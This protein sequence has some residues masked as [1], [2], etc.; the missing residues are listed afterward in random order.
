MNKNFIKI[1][2]IL[3]IFFILFYEKNIWGYYYFNDFSNPS[4]VSNNFDLDFRYGRVGVCTNNG[5]TSTVT[6]ANGKCVFNGRVN[7]DDSDY[8]GLWVGRMVKFTNRKFTASEYNPFGVLIVRDATRLDPQLEGDSWGASESWRHL[9]A[10]S[11]WIFVETGLN[12][13]SPEFSSYNDFI[14]MY[15]MMRDVFNL[16]NP[17]DD[18]S[19]PFSTWGMYISSESRLDL[20]SA[21]RADGKRIVNIVNNTNYKVEWCYENNYGAGTGDTALDGTPNARCTNKNR[22]GLLIT[23]NGSKVK[24]YINPNYDNNINNP[25]PDEFL[26]VG[27]ANVTWNSNISFMFGHESKRRDTEMEYFTVDEVLIRSVASNSIAEIYPYE[28]VTNKKINFTLYITN[29]FTINDSGIGE[30]IIE[31]P[32]GYSLWDLSTISVYSYYG[33]GSVSS[34]ISTLKQLTLITTGTL[35]GN[36]EVLATTNGDNL[37]LQFFIGEPTTPGSNVINYD[38]PDKRI[39]VHFTLTSPVTPAP[40]GDEF[41]TYINCKKYN[42][43][44]YSKFATTGKKRVYSGDAV[45]FNKSTSLKVKVY[46][47][48]IAY[49]SLTPN[50]IYEGT[51]NT[52]YYYLS[53]TSTNPGTYITKLE[54]DIPQGFGIISAN[55]SSLRINNDD[56]YAYVTNN[57]VVIDYLGDNN[58]FPA[59]S[60]LDRVTIKAT[61]TPNISNE[62]NILWA[63]RIYST[64]LGAG[65]TYTK[66][67]EIYKSQNLLV[68]LEPPDVVAYIN[69]DLIYNNAK[70]NTFQYIVQNN[71]NPGNNVDKV[72]IILPQVFTNADSF[73][74]SIASVSSFTTIW[75]STNYIIVDYSKSGTNLP[76]GENDTISFRL[77]DTIPSLSAPTQ[78]E[79]PSYADNNN[80]DGFVL[81]SESSFGWSIDVI[82]PDPVGNGSI[83]KITNNATSSN[84]KSFYTSDVSNVFQYKIQNGDLGDSEND[85]IIAKIIIPTAFTQIYNV[86]STKIINDSQDIK[87]TNNTIV[88]YYTNT[89]NGHL[90]PGQIDKINF[91]VKDNITLPNSYTFDLKVANGKN[92]FQFYSTGNLGVENKILDAVYPPVMAKAFVKVDG[93]IGN[94]IDSSTVTNDLTYYIT[95]YGDI[96]N[97][98]KEIAIYFPTN[99]S[100]NQCIDIDS[101]IVTNS[102]NER[103]VSTGNY[104]FIDYQNEGKRLTGKSYDVIHFKMI[105]NISGNTSFKLSITGK[106]DLETSLLPSITGETQWVFIRIPPAYGKAS[107]SPESIFVV[108]AGEKVTNILHY[109]V[110]NYGWGSNKF[111]RARIKVPSV[112]A[113][114]VQNV[115]STHLTNESTS[116]IISSSYITINYTNENNPLPAQS[117]E[118][119]TFELVSDVTNPGVYGWPLEVDNGDGNGFVST[120]LM[121]GGTT[122]LSIIR[123]AKAA[124]SKVYNLYPSDVD[125]Y[126]TVTVSTL[127][128][129]ILHSGGTTDIRRAKI[130]IP[131]PFVTNNISVNPNFSGTA[132]ATYSIS[133]INTSNFIMINYPGGDFTSGE[134]NIIKI[135]VQDSWSTGET[136]CKWDSYVDFNDGNGFRKNIVAS[137]STTTVSF[138]FPPIQ[139]GGFSTPNNIMIDET[140]MT[141]SIYITNYDPVGN[142]IE[143]VKIILP[144]Q[145]TNIKDYTSTIIGT[146]IIYDKSKNIL[147]L[148]YYNF[149]T[150][151]SQYKKDTI[152][153]KGIDSVTSPVTNE[154]ILYAANSTNTN[155][156]V[157]VS[158][159]SGKNFNLNFYYPGYSS[160]VYVSPQQVDTTIT[161]NNLKYYVINNGSGTNYVTKVK[162]YINTNIYSTNSIF[163]SSL[164]KSEININENYILI[165]YIAS[166]TN[167]MPG[168]NDIINIKILDK[169]KYGDNT[170]T[171][172]SEI[173][174]NTS[175]SNYKTPAVLNGE[176]IN[177][178]YKMPSPRAKILQFNPIELPQ[179][180]KN[181][182]V[183]FSITNVGDGS[184]DIFKVKLCLPIYFTNKFNISKISSL[185]A[186]SKE[187]EKGNISLYYTNFTT[188]KKDNIQLILSNN[189]S[190]ASNL[191][192][193][194]T[195]SN[196]SHITNLTKNIKV[197][198]PPSVYITPNI[199][200]AVSL[201]NSFDFYILNNGTSSSNVKFAR[202]YFP[203]LITNISS[204]T[205]SLISTISINYTSNYIV[206]NYTNE[207]KS[208]TPGSFDKIS[209]IAYDSLARGYSNVLWNCKVDLSC[210]SLIDTYIEYNRSLAVSYIMPTLDAKAYIAPQNI[211]TTDISNQLVLSIVNEGEYNNDIQDIRVQIPFFFTN[212]KRITN[213]IPDTIYNYHS[214]SN[215]LHIQYNGDF[216]GGMSD[217]IKFEGFNNN[218][219]I[220]ELQFQVSGYNGNTNGYISLY[221]PADKTLI[222]TTKYPPNSIE[223][224]LENPTLY[225]IKTN[226]IIKYNIRNLSTGDSIK[227]IKISFNTNLLHLNRITSLWLGD[228]INSNYRIYSS[229]VEITYTNNLLTAQQKD[230]ISFYVSY[231]ISK[232][233]NLNMSSLITI[234]TETNTGVVPGNESVILNISKA[235]WGILKGNVYPLYKLIN[236]KVL[237]SEKD[238]VVN[239]YDNN[240]LVTFYKSDTGYYTLSKIPPG[241]YRLYFES[242]DLKAYTYKFSIESNIILTI[243]DIT[244]HNKPLS[245]D[246]PDKQSA[247]SY[248][249]YKSYLELKPGSFNKD[250]SVD[251]FIE[252]MT[253][254][255]Q[256]EDFEINPYIQN[257]SHNG[258]YVYRFNL[259]DINEQE[260]DGVALLNDGI[261]KLYYIS[262]MINST[263]WKE[264]DLGIYYFKEST[265]KWIPVG[266]V[267]DTVNKC[268]TTHINYVSRFFG[269]FAKSD[270]NSKGNIKNVVVSTRIFTPGRGNDDFSMVKISFSLADSVDNYTVS[271][272]DLR[273]D[274]IK[275]IERSG[276]YK[277]GSI[278]WDGKDEDGVIVKSG[279]YIYIIEADNETYKGSIL[280]VK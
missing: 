150:N 171:W 240:E 276:K 161:T 112:F 229:Y 48:P 41:K 64:V 3:I 69:P 241:E 141:Y 6:I 260:L 113:N 147:W 132:T 100:I 280:L 212:I 209:F 170:A 11:F 43:S 185:L 169:I 80:G 152:I 119:L 278:Y 30:I 2:Y 195:I 82:S 197:V 176:S 134:E 181:F 187:Y 196:F 219:I 216:K 142:S 8:V 57:K 129:K 210:N 199:V 227:D 72:K 25:Y 252:P 67:N 162:I 224:Y 116:I 13:A 136:N 31:K 89:N 16:E 86:S 5:T 63:S 37:K 151:I 275:R 128:Y 157:P 74:S 73:N 148:K 58:I 215:I 244:L 15:D 143:N 131:Y 211:Y 34:N 226:D 175:I 208:I 269:V 56:L 27:S 26:E 266:G 200:N 120:S 62:T 85:I 95:N 173:L 220:T 188:L 153:F 149:N 238:T 192:F 17:A 107:I 203:E 84:Q 42:G 180:L 87:I 46:A 146:N 265:K 232:K 126:S 184:N 159:V 205:S 253:N 191:S 10:M 130:L 245:A 135:I 166:N 223:T 262:S 53:T 32:V 104:I 68:R 250:F 168:K 59:Q 111:L 273:G 254:K 71:G 164:Y 7:Y 51:A 156:F 256:I 236:V 246:S 123:R 228:S 234:G 109:T 160:S 118:T 251:I 4:T 201:S 45:G 193:Y 207:G 99:G 182:N 237:N 96:G 167:I 259:L 125:I 93:A 206:L 102:L 36:G 115:L 70:Y 121:P 194:F 18:Q 1:F 249:D 117:S 257:V 247:M 54:I 186:S 218:S 9:N 88:L 235:P 178:L 225:L 145:L 214:N 268:V 263:G 81:N 155:D 91:K 172:N 79:F 158:P 75:G 94:I 55:V 221:P 12:N 14:L 76:A 33:T 133:N 65:V 35:A 28:I 183:N 61:T 258:V 177:I 60:G 38:T 20:T 190:P 272:Y 261:L 40:D 267:V 140:L 103:W 138:S 270:Y 78:Y 230:I 24:F 139:A 39:E 222:I 29:S 105:D 23:H 49:A 179:T 202:I 189:N 124:I 50:S 101:A 163:V 255:Y 83:F 279:V 44:T 127:Y 239:D 19:K 77:Y 213:D 98:I 47:D 233:T 277:Q 22:L 274:L 122:N 248:D 165:N 92:S 204:I 97:D 217:S 242:P 198:T 108:A 114:K 174:Y 52:F 90:L 21:L 271:I 231:H 137:N 264:N 110:Y 106:N 154:F 66:T 243:P 144:S